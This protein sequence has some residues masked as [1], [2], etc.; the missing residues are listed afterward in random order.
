M[1]IKQ[2]SSKKNFKI[3]QNDDLR[4]REKELKWARD[5]S[6]P[7]EILEKE[8]AYND[9]LEQICNRE[10]L[11]MSTF[12]LLHDEKPSRAMINLE[13]KVTGYSS[14]SKIHKPNSLYTPPEGGWQS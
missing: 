10:A 2:S 11:A 9:T 7:S 12:R 13:K 1:L 14:I 3:E 6:T 5:Y 8:N 4:E